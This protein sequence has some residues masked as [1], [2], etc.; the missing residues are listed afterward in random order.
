MSTSRAPAL[1]L[2]PRAGGGEPLGSSTELEIHGVRIRFSSNRAD[3]V[4][5]VP[6]HLGGFQAL[7]PGSPQIEVNA[8]WLEQ[9]EPETGD[10]FGGRAA[11]ERLGKRMRE[12]PDELVWFEILTAKGL[13][14]RFRLSGEHLAVD[15]RVHVDPEKRKAR[16]RDPARAREYFRAMT[17]L[18]YYPLAWYLE[19]FRGLYLLHASAVEL[20]GRALLFGGVGGVG[21]STTSVA[22]LCRAGAGFLSESLVFHDGH[23]VFG[24]YEPIRIAERGLE[25]LGE[26][27]GALIEAEISPGAKSKRVF[28]VAPSRLVQSAPIGA[29]FLPRFGSPA[30]LRRLDPEPSLDRLLAINTQSRKVN[31]YTYFAS[32]LEMKWPRPGRAA[33]RVARLEALLGSALLYELTLDPGSGLERVLECVR[34]GCQVVFE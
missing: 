16:K 34:E 24:C 14:L 9:E 33:G 21:K 26:T 19:H 7:G 31:D 29:I 18:L 20:G 1:D 13:Q 10:A 8:V 28:H 5:Y 32:A 27:R 30:G 25:L 2:R 3:L 11:L 15:A 6:A 12:G 17:H 23:R 22:L 4:A